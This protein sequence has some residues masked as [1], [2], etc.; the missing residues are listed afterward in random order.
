MP[1]NVCR[2][3]GARCGPLCSQHDHFAIGFSNRQLFGIITPPVTPIISCISDK[4]FVAK[5]INS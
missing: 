4:F 5:I 2:F 3:G 1:S